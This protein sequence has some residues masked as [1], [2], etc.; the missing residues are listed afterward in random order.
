MG[1]MIRA[2]S[3]RGFV[4]LVEEL[5]GAPDALLARFGIS[6]GSLEADD[7][8]VPITAHDRMLDAAAD[9]LGCPDFG[10]R[11]A[12]RQDLGILGPLAIAVESSSTVAEAL[13]CASRFMFVH[14]TAL[15]VDV[16]PDPH[17]R[18]GV[19]AL[20]YYKDL[21]ESMYSPQAMELGLGLF[22]R[23]S[24]ALLGGLTG[25]RSVEFPHGPVSPVRRYLDFFG[26]DV[27]FGAP[28]G[29]LCVERQV[30]DE[31]FATANE[32]TRGIALGHL[33]TQYPDSTGA[34]PARVR[35]AIAETLGVSAPSV[36]A[37]ARLLATHPRTLQRQLA[38]EGTS[39]ETVLDD[40]RRDAAHR[41]I[42]G[43]D[44]PLSQV[45]TL[46]AFTEQSSLSHAVRR[47]F[48][49]S[50]RELRRLG[51]GGAGA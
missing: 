6:R 9:A 43:T 12:E 10:L 36:V 35:L 8:L 4:P 16:R 33:T 26:C 24:V 29:A 21:R 14:S 13:R 46:V 20:T 25:L 1:P 2:A 39:F 18:R 31:R 15:S 11:L 44:L 49:L 32:T 37:V 45:T 28:A 38:R 48:G 17:G 40:V 30:L 34:I 47:W 41:F 42:T 5:G 22:H 19:V 7:E 51:S 3:L 50:P 27:R 23:V